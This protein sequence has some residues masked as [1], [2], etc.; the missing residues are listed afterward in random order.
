[1][2]VARGAA[3][4]DAVIARFHAGIAIRRPHRQPELQELAHRRRACRHAMPEAKI[5]DESE[6][7]RREHHLK[8]FTSRVVHRNHQIR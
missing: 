6:L 5:I 3:A 8:P 4:E 2:P 1:M 7:L